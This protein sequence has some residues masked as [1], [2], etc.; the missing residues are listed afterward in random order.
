MPAR[1]CWSTQRCRCASASTRSTRAALYNFL[2]QQFRLKRALSV[3]LDRQRR[4]LEAARELNDDLSA[5][6]AL[7]VNCGV[8]VEGKPATLSA[9]CVQSIELRITSTDTVRFWTGIVSTVFAKTLS[10]TFTMTVVALYLWAR[11]TRLGA[12][13]SVYVMADL[14]ELVNH[15]SLALYTSRADVVRAITAVC[16]SCAKI[17]E[18]RA[19]VTATASAQTK[20]RKRKK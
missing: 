5:C 9:K 19:P 8:K 7:L 12:D 20:K 17:Y 15:T 13:L 2:Q 1:C 14:L 16:H 3:Q 18:N 6:D 11:Q 4:A 10:Y